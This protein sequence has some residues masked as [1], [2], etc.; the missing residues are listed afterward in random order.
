MHTTTPIAN[1]TVIVVPSPDSSKI[2]LAVV[3]PSIT[4]AQ[5]PAIVSP[6][7]QFQL[8][9]GLDTLED[10]TTLSCKVYQHYH[11]IINIC[12]MMDSI[13]KSSFLQITFH[14]NIFISALSHGSGNPVFKSLAFLIQQLVTPSVHEEV[15]IE[16]KK[17]E[18][19]GC[20]GGTTSLDLLNHMHQLQHTSCHDPAN[21]QMKLSHGGNWW[22]DIYFY[23]K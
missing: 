6:A 23:L 21:L 8:V 14:K 22:Y 12:F 20:V 17:W 3:L 11:N 18:T 9:C 7:Q 1:A 15:S 4:S 5:F 13:S 19:I 10:H 2:S 16:Y